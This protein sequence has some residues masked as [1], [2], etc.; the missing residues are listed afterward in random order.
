VEHKKVFYAD[1]KAKQTPSILQGKGEHIGSPL[2]SV[3]QWF[4]TMTTNEYVRGIKLNNWR[5]FT[6]KLWQR[7]YYEHIMH[8]DN[9]LKHVCKY[10]KENPINWYVFSK[11]RVYALFF[12]NVK[13]PSRLLRSAQAA[14]RRF[15]RLNICRLL[16]MY[17]NCTF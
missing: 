15:Y 8:N 17:I 10:I 5:F 7:D 14:R 13:E 12:R 6:G 1:N 2:H 4:K 9:E 16:N 11:L 3:V